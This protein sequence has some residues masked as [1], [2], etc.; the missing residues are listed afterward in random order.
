METKRALK[1]RCWDLE[2]AVRCAVA[3]LAME[4]EFGPYAKDGTFRHPSTTRDVENYLRRA[5]E[6]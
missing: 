6:R 1:R 2:Y 5:L 3:E 4:N